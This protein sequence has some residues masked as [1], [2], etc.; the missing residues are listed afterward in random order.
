MAFRAAATARSTSSAPLSAHRASRRPVAGFRTSNVLPDAA[1]THWPPMQ[2]RRGAE[3]RS[4][5]R[6][7]ATR[8]IDSVLDG[9]GFSVQG[10]VR[11]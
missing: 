8:G 3:A 5:W 4:R 11:G 2:F 10:R 7:S 9:H 6:V 1:S